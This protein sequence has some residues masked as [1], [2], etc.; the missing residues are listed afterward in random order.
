MANIKKVIM[1][2]ESRKGLLEGMKVVAEAVASTAGA[3]GRNVCIAQQWGAPSMTK[4]GYKTSKSIELDGIQGEGVKLIQQAAEKQNTESGDATTLVTTLTYNLAKEGMKYIEKGC[5]TTMIRS[6]MEEACQDIVSCLKDMSK[7]ITTNEEVKQ[8]ATISANGDTVIGGLIAEAVEKIGKTGVIT[9]ENSK[10]YRTTLEVVEGLQFDNGFM[11]PYFMTN[12]EKSLTEYDNPLL[13]LTDMKINSLKQILPLLESASQSGRPIVII[14]DDMDNDPLSNLVVNQLRG[15]LKS[16]VIKAPSFGDFRQMEM[17][18]IATLTGA[19]YISEKFGTDLSKLDITA[20][21]SCQKIKVSPTKTVI[22]K[23]LGDKDKIKQRINEITQEIDN[24]E[25]NYDKTKLQERLAKMTNGIALI[26][27]GGATEAEIQEKKDRVEDAICSTK[28]AL[29][30]G[31]LPGGGVAL[32]RAGDYPEHSKM[33]ED[34]SRG[35][36][37]VMRIIQQHICQLADNA[38]VSGKVV[39]ETVKNKTKNVGY[40]LISKEY[41]DM[42]EAGIID[43]TKCIRTA[44]EIATSTAGAFLTTN[45]V[46]IPDIDENMKRAKL[47][48][49]MPP[50]M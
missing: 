29:E 40:D 16:C 48:G 19:T 1:D 37:L 43:A 22:I 24:S 35:Y 8:V 45:C 44:V 42:F 34:M 26:R 2:D 36:N 20:C 12:P 7:E 10:D 3:C 21:G 11:S 30:E 25:S 46:V 23:G 6:G 9:C 27:V 32:V 15:T 14:C 41:V 4:D 39:L 49:Q 31:I 13:F 38:G 47:M 28:C 33:P 50:A 17:E 5:N 18:D